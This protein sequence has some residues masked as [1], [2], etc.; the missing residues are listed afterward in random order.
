MFRHKY[1][2]ALCAIKQ[3]S[4]TDNLMFG[5]ARDAKLLVFYFYKLYQI[6]NVYIFEIKNITKQLSFSDFL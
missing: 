2:V 6:K 1:L 3:T 4:K 5:I